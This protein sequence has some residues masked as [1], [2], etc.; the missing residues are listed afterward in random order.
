[1]HNGEGESDGKMPKV[2]ERQQETQSR[3]ALWTKNRS[4]EDVGT[5]LP[6]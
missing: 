6:V 4:E 2:F 5:D 1:M 3:V